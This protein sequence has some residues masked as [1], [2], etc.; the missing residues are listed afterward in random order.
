M[1]F[2]LP[3]LIDKDLKNLS[4]FST[5]FFPGCRFLTSGLINMTS[6]FD[7]C[8]S[9]ASAR[10]FDCEKLTLVILVTFYFLLNKGKIGSF[11]NAFI[12]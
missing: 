9:G 10:F 7:R 5:Q 3:S 6:G 12:R 11:I 8:T 4:I 1:I 2:S